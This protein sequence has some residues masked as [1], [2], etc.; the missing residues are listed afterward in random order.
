MFLRGGQ[1][2]KAK[3]FFEE[4]NFEK[5]KRF[6][7]KA[8]LSDQLWKGKSFPPK[9][10]LEWPTNFVKANY[11]L[12]KPNLSHQLWKGKLFLQ[13]CPTLERLNISFSDQTW[14]TKFERLITSSSVPNF[15]R[16]NIFLERQTRQANFEKAKY[17]FKNQF[18]KS[19]Y[20][21]IS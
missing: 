1:L 18:W 11:F 3:C 13:V 15:E 2:E 10:K 4:A 20:F 21:C 7:E 9:A 17:L 19:K 8:N 14:V 5:A 6:F 16:L 12:Q